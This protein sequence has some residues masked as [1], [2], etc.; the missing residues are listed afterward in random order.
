MNGAPQKPDTTPLEDALRALPDEAP[1]AGLEGRILDALKEQREVLHPRATKKDGT[2]LPR[3]LAAA[4][5]LVLVAAIQAPRLAE[6]SRGR[7]SSDA[8]RVAMSPSPAP[9]QTAAKTATRPSVDA[10]R[11]PRGRAE[12]DGGKPGAT[13]APAKRSESELAFQE[14]ILPGARAD[15]A[16][17]APPSPVD[18]AA[19]ESGPSPYDR[20][21]DYG[22]PA[23]PWKDLSDDRQ[24]VT[25]S[26]LDVEVR[27]VEKACDRT[28]QVIE[29]A[30]GIVFSLDMTVHERGAASAKIVAR[31]PSNA[32]DGVLAQVRDLGTVQ[33]LVT[34]SKDVTQQYRDQGGEIRSQ[35]RTLQQLEDDLQQETNPA[36]RRALERRIA[37]MKDVQAQREQR[38]KYLSE[39]TH[40]VGL[41]ITLNGHRGPVT[42]FTRIVP[43]VGETVLWV[44]VTSIFWGPLAVI[45]WVLRRRNLARG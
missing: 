10:A 35:E 6:L 11:D 14:G 4:A 36:R 2:W 9:P 22:A 5:V 43:N 17:G 21:P 24:R 26:R 16:P 25:T 33:R 12:I 38:L 45:A 34:D 37:E 27:D 19:S 29:D 41:E 1:P 30:G 8:Q 44:L 13:M 40:S 31:V 39:H 28:K 42:F 7:R 3:L 15:R 18:S 20:T 23:E 32:A